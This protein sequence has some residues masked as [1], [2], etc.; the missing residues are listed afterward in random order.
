M[1]D[2]LTV[3]DIKT[4]ALGGEAR[5]AMMIE[6]T[7]PIQMLVLAVQLY[8]MGHHVLSAADELRLTDAL[9]EHVDFADALG[10]AAK[11]AE[12]AFDAAALAV[13]HLYQLCQHCDCEECTQRRRRENAGIN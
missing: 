9:P 12:V 7:P 3:E 4:A 6:G 13:Y 8:E 11:A 5:L 1:T 10:T 2:D